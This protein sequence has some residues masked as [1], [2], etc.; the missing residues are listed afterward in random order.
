MHWSS[1]LASRAGL[2][3]TGISSFLQTHYHIPH[4]ILM[5]TRNDWLNLSCTF[6]LNTWLTWRKF[7]AE[8]H[9]RATRATWQP[10]DC[11]VMLIWHFVSL[12]LKHNFQQC[13]CEKQFLQSVFH[14]CHLAWLKQNEV[15]TRSTSLRIK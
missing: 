1:S 11:H 14:S 13:R 7:S 12:W 9:V 2:A 10:C 3:L 6:R 4:D 15:C 5:G 8:L